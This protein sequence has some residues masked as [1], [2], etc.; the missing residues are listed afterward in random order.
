MTLN[1]IEDLKWKLLMLKFKLL[2]ASDERK[3]EHLRRK[4]CRF[5]IHKLVQRRV[6]KSTSLSKRMKTVYYLGC[7]FCGF[8]FFTTKQDKEWY[9]KNFY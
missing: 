6:M 2:M 5:G 1:I 7:D 3:K 8:K 4:Y 9:H